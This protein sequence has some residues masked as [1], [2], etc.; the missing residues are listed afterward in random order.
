MNSS[1]LILVALI[2]FEPAKRTRLAALLDDC[3]ALAARWRTAGVAESDLWIVE[4]ENARGAGGGLVEVAG[5]QPMR[6]RPWEMPQPVVFTQPLHE[7]LAGH[8]SFDPAS[9]QS[10]GMLL[11]QIAPALM[12]KLVQQVLVD[13]LVANGASFT[14]SN[15]IHVQEGRHPLA[16]LD[17]NGATG[18]APHATLAAIRRADWLL[19]PRDD[20][21]IP[22][23]FRTTSTEEVLWRFA[24]RT[25]RPDLLPGRYQRLPIYLRRLPTLPPRELSDRHFALLRELA[26]APRTFA[27]LGDRLGASD[28]G[29]RRD[30]GALFLISAITCDPGRSR[31]A[32]EQRRSAEL[33]HHEDLSIVGVQPADVGQLT[34]PGFARA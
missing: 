2:G 14:R 8:R 18:V 3:S 27:E 4:A 28:P 32:R 16:V 23:G 17:F 29:L 22:L 1:P 31:A 13:H 26:Y 10:L 34:A 9:M 7:S 20:A 11:T 19:K 12:P 6:F 25:D 24:T 15:V 30:L 33:E 5:A 21:S